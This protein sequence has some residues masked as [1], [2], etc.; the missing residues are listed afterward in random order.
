MDRQPEGPVKEFLLYLASFA[1]LLGV[2]AFITYVLA[3]LIFGS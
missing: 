2:L 1:I 3:P